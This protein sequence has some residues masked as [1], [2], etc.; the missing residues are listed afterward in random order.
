VFEDEKDGVFGLRIRPVLE[1]DTGTG[2]IVNA[3]GLETEKALWGK[4]SEWC[5][6]LGDHS[7]GKARNRHSGRPAEIRARRSVGTLALYGLF[8]A[9]PFGFRSSPM[10]SRR[11]AQ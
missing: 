4:P 1:E 11:A 2:H 7:L 3:Q 9:N 10:T 8:A 5:E 6:L